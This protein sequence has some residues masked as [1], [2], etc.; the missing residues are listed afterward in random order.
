MATYQLQPMKS[1]TSSTQD[2]EIPEESSIG[3]K[4]RRS[5]RPSTS[6]RKSLVNNA[7]KKRL[8]P[9]PDSTILSDSSSSI[10]TVDSIVVQPKKSILKRLSPNQ[11]R[12]SHTRRVAFH[13]QVKVLLFASPSRRTS[14]KLIDDE[15]RKKTG[16]GNRDELRTSSIVTRRTSKLFNLTEPTPTVS[17]T[18]TPVATEKKAIEPIYPSLIDCDKPIDSLIHV[19]YGGVWSVDREA[20][21]QRTF[22]FFSFSSVRT[23][24]SII[25]DRFRRER[26]AI[27]RVRVPN[28]SKF[29]RF[30]CRN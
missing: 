1:D 20:K 9:T 2:E 22:R 3:K 19:L 30:H 10:S 11:T 28:K 24:R 14:S 26:S 29:I 15:T 7:R 16:N 23:T 18:K 5:R 13:D 8:L 25:F 21:A 17:P 4:L 27:W 12:L 6:A